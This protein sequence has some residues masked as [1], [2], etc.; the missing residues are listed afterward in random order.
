MSLAEFSFTSRARPIVEIGV[1]D[2]RLPV[3]Q[4]RW[5][6]QRW[7]AADALWA[8]SEPTWLDVTC[9]VRSVDCE[10]GRRRS[11]DRF[12]AGAATIV[13][14]NASGWADPVPP[15]T[16]LALTMRPGRAIR[17]GIDHETLGRCWRYRGFIDAVDPTYDPVDTD[18]VTLSCL[19]ALGEVNRAKMVPL[20]DPVG[21]GETASAR[22]SRI[23]TRA[24]WR[25]NQ[26]DIAP[27]S[28]TVVG[29]TLGGQVA[30][31]LGQAADSAGGSV[32]GDLEGRIAFRPRDWQTFAPDIPPDGTIGNVDATDV[33][34]VQWR[35]PFERAD[36][37]TRAIMGRDLETAVQLDDVP[38]AVL[39]GIEPF[40]RVDLVTATNADLTMLAQRALRTRAADTAP[41]V[42]SVSLSA[43]TAENALDLMCALDVYKP[44]RY[45]CRLAYDRGLVF[46]DQYLVTGVTHHIERDAWTAL[47]N[48]DLAA[49]YAA[50]GGRWDSSEWDRATW[51]ATATVA[52][53]DLRD[54]LRAMEPA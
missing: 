52:L 15:S 6:V 38:G 21:N 13:V 5:D 4:A 28:V 24:M 3:G 16:P 26:R 48:L 45:R 25:A 7:D 22:I 19:D 11:T 40:E 32:F 14:D 51:S 50:A 9:E 47:V 29:S 20:A 34:P 54:S 44:S 17:V 12:V 30:D 35:R 31:L 46:D 27:T 23:L 1:G 41:R 39:Y 43:D 49:P 42:R 18:T 53:T 37:A 2:T 10:Y 8:G 36:I 33:C